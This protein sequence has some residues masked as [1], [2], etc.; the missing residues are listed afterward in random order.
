MVLMSWA[1]NKEGKT[2]A[3]GIMLLLLQLLLL[4]MMLRRQLPLVICCLAVAVEVDGVVALPV[5][6]TAA[7]TS[8]IVQVALLGT[9]AL[10]ASGSQTAHLAVLVHSIADP[11]DTGIAT[12]GLVGGIHADDLVDL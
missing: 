7:T 5:L 1:S 6:A 4:M 11:V 10:A 9:T 12:D 3:S 2:K 8:A